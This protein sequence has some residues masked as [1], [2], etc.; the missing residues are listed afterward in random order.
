LNKRAISKEASAAT[1]VR[2]EWITS[3]RFTSGRTGVLTWRVANAIP[4]E[5]CLDEL[6]RREDT[7]YLVH[8]PV[9][10]RGCPTLSSEKGLPILLLLREKPRR[11]TGRGDLHPITFCCYQR[12]PLLGTIRARNLFVKVLG[13]VRARHEFLLVGYVVMPE[14]VHLLMSEP[15]KLR[16][17]RVLQVLKQRVSREM[18]GKRRGAS[19]RQLG[20]KFPEPEGELRRFWQRRFYD[21]NVWSREKKKEKLKYMHANPVKRE[22]VRNP[23]D[24]PWSSYSFCVSGETGLIPMDAVD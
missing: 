4:L 6:L 15:R 8:R 14:H 2:A 20:L 24:W 10:K 1:A 19:A 13:E 3:S 18:R 23:Q 22:L 17:S 11:Y 7:T 12:R 9:M 21:F 16:P 5:F